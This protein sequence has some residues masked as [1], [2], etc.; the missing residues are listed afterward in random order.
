MIPT[1]FPQLKSG[2]IL[3]FTK[4]SKNLAIDCTSTEGT[5]TLPLS[6]FL[7]QNAYQTCINKS[8]EKLTI[9]QISFFVINKTAK[10][11]R[12]KTLMC[13]DDDIKLVD[14]PLMVFQN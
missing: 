13:I 8:F 11:H 14:F 7:K 9:Q 1:L 2:D 12:V 4:S 10:I 3:H 6:V 5:I